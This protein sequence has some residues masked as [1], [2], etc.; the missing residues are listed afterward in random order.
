[1]IEKAELSQRLAH[2]TVEERALLFERLREKRL[3]ATSGPSQSIPRR[4]ADAPPPL[5][6]AQQRLWFLD[7]LA[8]GDP[9]YNVPNVLRLRGPLVPE[10]L[11]RAL[12]AVADRHESL[13]T[14]FGMAGGEPVQLISPRSEVALTV[15]DLSGVGDEEA[16]RLCREEV[17]RPFDLAAGP[18]LRALLLRRGP[19]DHV[20]ALTMH[21]I[22][23]DG[24]SMGVLVHEMV[25]LYEA[26]ASGAAANG[27][28]PELP[29]QYADFAVWQRERLSGER[30]EALIATW[31]RRLGNPPEPL[32]LPTDRP[33]PAVKTS[34]GASQPLRL[35]PGT[36]E[37]V[38]DLAHRERATPFMILLAAFQTQLHRYS[39][40]DDLVVGTPVANRDLAELKGLI[41]FF[42]NTLAL[43]GDLSGDPS[44]RDLLQRVREVALEA[45]AHQD[46][47]FEKLVEELRPERD[48]SRS[49]VFQVAF[50]LQNTPGAEPALGGVRIE[51]VPV[52]AGTAKF[53][54]DLAFDH[55]GLSGDLGFNT[56]LFDAATAARMAAH[57]RTL[58]AG[59]VADPGRS[60]SELPLLGEEE[61]RQL[62]VDWNRTETAPA[63]GLSPARRF[64]AIAASR[65]D[66]VV[67]AW[68]GGTLTYREL[69][70]RANRLARHLRRL[71]VGP[72]SIVAVLLDRSPE[73]C[74]AALAVAKA[75]GAYLPLDPSSPE[76][77]IAAALE[78]AGARVVL[79][80]EAFA[81]LDGE[82]APGDPLI[83]LDHP[84]SLA[85]VIFTS[86]STGR[87][88][89]VAV[90]RASLENLIDFHHRVRPMAPGDRAALTA[91]P[92][93][94]GSVWEIWAFLTGGA[95]FHIPD[96][97]VRLSPSRF[98]EWLAR[99][100]IRHCFL[101]TPLAEALLAEPAVREARLRTLFTGGDR[102][103]RLAGDPG[104][105]VD[106]LYGPSEATVICAWA[107]DVERQA[108]D[109]SV[110]GPIGNAR[111]YVLDRFL[112]PL[113]VGVPG[114]LWVGG[115]VLSR[116]YLGRPDLTAERYRPDPFGEP[117]ARMYGTG[118]LARRRPDGDLEV[119]GRIDHQVKIRGVRVELGEIEQALLAHSGVRQAVVL[120]RGEG[121][122]KRLVAYLV[123][124][125]LDFLELRAHLR[126]GLPE[127]MVP[128]SYALLESLPLTPNGK[129]DRAALERLEVAEA[130]RGSEFAPPSSETERDVAA[131]WAEVL[132]VERMGVDDNFF[133]LGG[134]SLLLARVQTLLGERLGRPVPLLKLIE[135]STVRTLAR[136]L[137]GGAEEAPAAEESRDRARRQRQGLELQRRRMA[138]RGGVK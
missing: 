34:A 89:G 20:L 68:T 112:Q 60:L 100:D 119:L 134:H 21:H 35:D 30:L 69:D 120:P 24:W 95:T 84:R 46:L 32:R 111:I 98:A 29:I 54:L 51:G 36:A 77:R 118:D 52:E 28:L 8:P 13:R 75:G 1:M 81:A 63:Q 48:P 78:D 128:A 127:A 18:L 66:D 47:P 44:F 133:D 65:P 25:T 23:S 2:L 16:E 110:G 53:D 93:F 43:R 97:E 129:V 71:G 33:R 79:T 56:D 12:A 102:L 125:P 11:S 14:T 15:V 49:P 105:P 4:R 115:R 99:E 124:E 91:G 107:R 96:E 73:L 26:F 40:Q 103:R 3:S 17:R 138:G 6:F 104:F 64:E 108:G 10:A 121:A 85:Y 76:E 19:G 59:A 94:D 83:P 131:L 116:G 86:G 55:D 136:F 88:K 39:G 42:V 72:E 31:K 57:F 135:H 62:L 82:D 113:P 114:E 80:R 92:A 7:R 74:L 50:A 130:P 109:P 126:R 27:V 67:L 5:S 132:G 90:E 9:T 87:A 106:N 70:R 101:A 117:G 61:R 122:G 37:R 22:V 137:D 123:A 58:V 38:R 45:Y 41:G